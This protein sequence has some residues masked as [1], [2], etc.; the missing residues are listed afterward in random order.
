MKL[1]SVCLAEQEMDRK[2]QDHQQELQRLR[3]QTDIDTEQL[4][5]EAK[6]KKEM[7]EVGFF[8]Q[9]CINSFS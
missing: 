4:D 7:K 1:L 8:C 9:S 5:H 3:Q 6:L 2:L